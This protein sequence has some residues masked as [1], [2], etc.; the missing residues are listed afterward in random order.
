MK[1]VQKVQKVHLGCGNNIFE[2]WINVDILVRDEILT[3]DLSVDLPFDDC[4]VDFFF[5][6]HFF[7]H[8]TKKD[9]L[10]HLKEIYRCL[11]VGGVSK[12]VVPDLDFLVYNYS[13]NNIKAY[14]NSGWN[15]VSRC[16]MINEG[17]SCWDHKYMYNAEELFSSHEKSSFAD[18]IFTA[19]NYSSHKEFRGI[20]RRKDCSEISIEATKR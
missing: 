13:S 8:L 15:P 2:D 19:Y 17:M 18:I 16:D 12:I 14:L 5:S 1:K 11:K 10:N 9:G 6:E 4:S 20:G 3:H 7:E